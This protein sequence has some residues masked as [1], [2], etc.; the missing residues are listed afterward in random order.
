MSTEL[1]LQTLEQDAP[2][3]S[4]NLSDMLFILFR[5]KWKIIFCATA[6]IFA[7]T[8]AYFFVPPLYESQAKLLVRYVVEKSSIDPLDSSSAVPGGSQGAILINSEVEILNSRDLIEEVVDTIGIKRLLRGPGGKDPK[9]EAVR[10]ILADLRVT[11]IKESNI[12]SVSYK[13]RDPELAVRVLQELVRLYFEKHLEVHRSTGAFDFVRQEAD[14]LRERLNQTEKALK[15]LQ[16]S[17]GIISPAETA[18]SLDAEL[19]KSQQ[20]LSAASAEFAA[21]QARVTEIERGLAWAQTEQSANN[22]TQQVSSEVIQEYQALVGRLTHLRQTETD[23]L[24]RYRPESRIVQVKHAQIEELDMQRQS[25]EK[26]YPGLLETVPAA[27]SS[28]SARRDLV[29]EKAQLE[30]LKAKTEALKSRVSTVQ[31]RLKTASEIGPQIAE[32]QRRKEVE[33]ASY[34]YYETSLEKARID[35]RLDPARIPNISVVQRP[36][37]AEKYSKD[38]RTTVLGLAL[39]GGMAGLAIALLIE[40]VLDR[41]VKRPLEFEARL[42][43][44]LLLSIPH[45]GRNGHSRLR[46]HNAGR[47]PLA[48]P[49]ESAS[50]NIDPW[51]S[52]HFIRPFCEALRDRLILEFEFKRMTHKPKLVAVTGISEGAGAS[53]LAA[54]L[55]ASLSELSKGRVLL[56][57][58][59]FDP[60]RFFGL[61]AEFKAGDFDYVIFDMPTLSNTSTTV[62]M[63]GFMDKVLLVVEAEVSNREIVKRAYAGLA[64]TKADV[65][66]VL[67]KSR[68]HGP[69]WLQTDF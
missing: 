30:A 8:A 16:D 13:N 27:P 39:G 54:G 62:P 10:G 63:A 48:D 2:P 44:P 33:E 37:T 26:K 12:I 67:N 45:F 25:L 18:A 3:S 14:Q 43:I 11:A 65:S 69:R 23:L 60:K 28:Q 4:L 20:E 15:Q 53:T 40:L 47:E 42:S 46:L 32:L 5:H 38:K 68:S 64:A 22:A 61:I 50:L 1:A 51:E 55:A 7:A 29:S 66:A 36:L 35:E 34:K 49:E 24:A 52:D 57:D 31:A 9:D 19:V 41:S 59:P 56:V 58:E 6:G 21:Q 17:A